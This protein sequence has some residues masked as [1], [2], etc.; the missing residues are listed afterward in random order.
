MGVHFVTFHFYSSASNFFVVTLAVVDLC[1]FTS[2]SGSYE[3]FQKA[4]NFCKHA[5][6]YPNLMSAVERECSITDADIMKFLGV[7]ETNRDCYQS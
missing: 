2:L 5:S 1:L 4:V 3:H 6:S 7:L